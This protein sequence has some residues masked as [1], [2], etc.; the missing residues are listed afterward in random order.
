MTL[1]LANG[2]RDE[3]AASLADP[4]RR[5]RQITWSRS[6]CRW[7]WAKLY[8]V[9]LEVDLASGEVLKSEPVSPEHLQLC[10]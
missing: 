3:R 7:R 8:R 1:G 4:R 10:T 6:R 2:H 5:Y 9:L